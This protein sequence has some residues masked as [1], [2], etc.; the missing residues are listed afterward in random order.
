[1]IHFGLQAV[2]AGANPIEVKRGLDKTT[3]F[4]V[5]KLKEHAKPVKG[6]QDI[7]VR[8]STRQ[9][10]PCKLQLVAQRFLTLTKR[11]WGE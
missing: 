8:L 3:D 6:R 5:S 10:M 2:T 7:K 11:S 9:G 1:M 4:L